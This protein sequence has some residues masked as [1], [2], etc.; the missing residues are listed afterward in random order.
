MAVSVGNKFRTILYNSSA[1]PFTTG[2]LISLDILKSTAQSIRVPALATAKLFGDLKSIAPG[3]QGLPMRVRRRISGR[4]AGRLGHILIPQGMGFASR[5][6]NKYYGKFVTKSLNN[7]FND[8]VRYQ[9]R[10]DGS[11]MT[12]TTKANL[13][14]N[15][16][17]STSRQ[18]KGAKNDLGNLG[19][20]LG[21][22]NPAAI[23]R[24]IQLQMI[25]SGMG[26][27]AAP[28]Q[29]GRLRSSIILRGFKS[30]GEGL[31]EGHLT[32]GGSESSPI[33]GEADEAPYWWK[34]V[35]G[36]YY[37]PRTPNNFAPARQFGWFG[38]SVGQGLSLSLPN[39]T[40][41]KVDNGQ[42]ETDVKIGSKVSFMLL[43]PPRP[44]DDAEEISMR[45]KYPLPSNYG[46]GE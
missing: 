30:G 36:G 2:D 22:F 15:L 44:K 39:G 8:K 46:D 42:Q 16:K 1:R 11:R 10:L 31:I 6:M 17:N 4:V 14:K 25:G 9:M 3:G 45:N 23:L 5:L 13:S 33:G 28:I 24:K 21:E 34:T 41:L 37:K 32:I 27:S 43:Q 40:E 29:T 38:R 7:Y 26:T 20:N 19:I 18:Y 12:A 35:Y